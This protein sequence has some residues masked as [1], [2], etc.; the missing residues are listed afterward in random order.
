MSRDTT[1]PW[2]PDT[3]CEYSPSCLSCPL[4]ACKYEMPLPRQ[5]FM[6]RARE[7]ARVRA[8]QGLTARQLAARFGVSVRSVHRAL[9]YVRVRDSRC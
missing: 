7:I 6:E 5:E 1:L 9:Q 2:L 8:A 4:P 3:G